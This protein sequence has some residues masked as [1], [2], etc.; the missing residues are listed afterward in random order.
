M[1]IQENERHQKLGG[2]CH[3]FAGD[4]VKHISMG[5]WQKEQICLKRRNVGGNCE[6]LDMGDKREER[7][8][9]PRS[10]CIRTQ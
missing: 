6:S 1:R 7:S 4:E 9:M 10:G 2:C 3:H 8:L 5:L